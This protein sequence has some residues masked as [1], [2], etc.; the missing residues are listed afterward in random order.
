MGAIAATDKAS[1]RIAPA[2]IRRSASEKMSERSAPGGVR[3]DTD[4]AAGTDRAAPSSQSDTRIPDIAVRPGRAGHIRTAGIAPTLPSSQ[5][6]RRPDSPAVKASLHTT[7]LMNALR[8]AKTR[9]PREHQRSI[10]G[11][12]S[13]TIQ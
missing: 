12:L 2:A 9:R 3:T 10:W 1:P 4:A 11:V 8:Y 5:P 6:H 13:H 7:F